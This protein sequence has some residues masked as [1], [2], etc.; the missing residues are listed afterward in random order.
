MLGLHGLTSTWKTF[1]FRGEQL[2]GDELQLVVARP[3]GSWAPRDDC[4]RDVRLGATSSR[5][6]IIEPGELGCWTQG[7]PGLTP[8]HS[9]ELVLTIPTVIPN[10][11]SQSPPRTDDT[12][13]V[14][15]LGFDPAIIRSITPSEYVRPRP[16]KGCT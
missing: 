10:A 8:G 13:S 2:G 6:D 14:V 16:S 1:D 5:V 9:S 11:S 7:Y 15:E 4:R 3:P 12:A